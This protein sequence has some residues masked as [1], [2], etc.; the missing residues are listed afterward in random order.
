M[1]FV[2]HTSIG[3][4]RDNPALC[5]TCHE[6]EDCR[7]ILMICPR[8]GD[9]RKVLF[10]RLYT[11]LTAPFHYEAIIFSDILEVLNSVHVFFFFKIIL[12]KFV[13]FFHITVFIM[14]YTLSH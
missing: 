4:D 2:V 6:L 14:N 8:F 3:L 11:L 9:H 13:F 10:N 1:L 12:C 7:H 5:S